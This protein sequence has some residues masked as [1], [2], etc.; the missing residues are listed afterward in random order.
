M[1]TYAVSLK[2]NRM[3][4]REASKLDRKSGGS[5]SIALIFF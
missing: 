5:P 1:T 4:I 3:K 2:G